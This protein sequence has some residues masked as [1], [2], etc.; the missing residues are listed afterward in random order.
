MTTRQTFLAEVAG[1]LRHVRGIA[2]EQW[3]GHPGYPAV[4]FDIAALSDEERWAIS[5]QLDD[6]L[7]EMSSPGFGEDHC[8]DE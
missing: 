1:P 5:D 3:E 6:I 8:V 7:S 2:D 4:F